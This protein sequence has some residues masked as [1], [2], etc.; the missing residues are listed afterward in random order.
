M[1][2]ILPNPR[3]APVTMA[4]VRADAAVRGAAHADHA[5]QCG[6]TASPRNSFVGE[7]NAFEFA[8][9]CFGPLIRLIVGGRARYLRR[10]TGKGKSCNPTP[11]EWLV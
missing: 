5:R 4:H 8:H 9:L 7:K 6:N 11:T 3:P 2:G 1:E 10:L